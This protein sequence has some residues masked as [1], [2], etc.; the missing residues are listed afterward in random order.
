MDYIVRSGLLAP[1]NFAVLSR[2]NEHVPDAPVF[3]PASDFRCVLPWR[4][5]KQG[6]Y[7]SLYF[8][9]TLVR[10]CCAGGGAQTAR[11]AS[12]QQFIV[13]RCLSFCPT[14]LTLVSD[15]QSPQ[16]RVATLSN[17]SP[18]LCY[19]TAD[20]YS[21][22]TSHRFLWCVAP[23]FFCISRLPNPVPPFSSREITQR[24]IAGASFVFGRAV[25]DL[26]QVR[27]RGE[28][29]GHLLTLTPA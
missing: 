12:L 20:H 21:W 6:L 29:S 7:V 18:A 24:C 25:N 26:W 16:H 19:L 27:R 2:Q 5:S 1:Y 15:A 11:M 17:G 9:D 3:D 8:C 28:S 14:S 23:S 4:S 22:F 13:T 10:Y